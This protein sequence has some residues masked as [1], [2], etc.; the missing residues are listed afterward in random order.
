MAEVC[1][2]GVESNLLSYVCLYISNV[3]VSELEYIKFMLVAM[4]KVDGALIDELCKQFKELDQTGD[5]NITKQDLK[6]MVTRKM[7]KVSHKLKLHS[8]KKRLLKTKSSAIGD[9]VDQMV[10]RSSSSDEQE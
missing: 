3:T 8:Y 4:H 6:I 10:L 1:C 7:R 2:V 9:A 5:G